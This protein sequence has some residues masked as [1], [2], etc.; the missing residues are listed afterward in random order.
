MSAEKRRPA[1]ERRPDRKPLRRYL[2][3][4]G[5]PVQAWRH[6]LDYLD[7]L[8]VLRWVFIAEAVVLTA[9]LAVGR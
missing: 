5:G 2:R 8:G 9:L 1:R 7:P 3:P 4:A 6:S